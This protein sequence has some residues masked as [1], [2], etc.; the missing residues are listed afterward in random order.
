MEKSV[1]CS[2]RG[3]RGVDQL[4]VRCTTCCRGREGKIVEN[5]KGRATTIELS[6]KKDNFSELY[7]WYIKGRSLS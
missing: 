1:A 6:D 7:S 3:S 4:T 2:R 5:I